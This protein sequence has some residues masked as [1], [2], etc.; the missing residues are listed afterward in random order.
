MTQTAFDIRETLR[1]LAFIAFHPGSSVTEPICAS[2][3]TLIDVMAKSC[4]DMDVYMALREFHMKSLQHAQII[5]QGSR[6]EGSLSP[7]LYIDE[8]NSAESTAVFADFQNV[9]AGFGLH[10]ADRSG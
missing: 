7:E 2:S 8:L 5:A 10:I 3:E 1:E 9:L 4:L 6:M